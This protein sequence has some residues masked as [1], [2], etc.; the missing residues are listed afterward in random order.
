MGTI[1][2]CTIATVFAATQIN[3]FSFFCSQL[4]RLEFSGLVATITKGLT[5]TQTTRAPVIGFSSFD[6]GSVGGFLSDFWLHGDT[7]MVG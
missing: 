1:T 2:K 3:C 6:V 7:F 5:F 4:H